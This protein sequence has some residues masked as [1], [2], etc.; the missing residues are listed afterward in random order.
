MARD[1]VLGRIIDVNGSYSSLWKYLTKI[2]DKGELSGSSDNGELEG[3]NDNW[4]FVI[5][6]FLVF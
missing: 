6:L 1:V 2:N 3:L 4:Q 5:L